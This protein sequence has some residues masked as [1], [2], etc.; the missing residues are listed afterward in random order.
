MSKQES[1]YNN[2]QQNNTQKDQVDL[3]KRRFMIGTVGTSMLMAFGGLGGIVADASAANLLANKSFNPNIWIELNAEGEVLINIAKAEMGQHIGTALARIVSDELGADWSFV[4]IHHVDSD[5]KWGF[6][7]TGGSWSVFQSFKPMSQAGAAGRISL[8]HAGAK[9]LGVSSSSCHTE[10]SFVMSGNKK[11]SFA[12]IIKKGSFDKI[13][14]PEEM[15]K[16]PLK[17]REKLKLVGKKSQAL[18]IPAK[19]N[20]SAKYGLDVELPGM[21][22][23]RPIVPPTRYG[24]KVKSVND[25]AAKGITGYLGYEMITDPS[26]TL[27]GWVVALA[28][29]YPAAMKAVQAISVS[30]Q[31]GPTANVSESDIQKEGQRLVDDKN[32]GFLFVDDGNVKAANAKAKSTLSS[33]YRTASAIHFPLEPLNATAEFVDGVCH[34]HTGNQWQSLT[35]PVVA[36]AL[37]LPA[38]NVVMHQYFL[39]GGFGRRLF[40]DYA[41]P[42]ALVAKKIGKP[43]KLIFTREDDSLFSQPRSPSV[44]RFDAAFDGDKLLSVEHAL[45]AGWPTLAMAPG[46]MPESVDKKG[47]VDPFSSSGADHWYSIENQ[48]V[49]LINN[50]L[51]Q[52]TFLPGWLRSVGPGWIGWGVESFIDELAI[53][54]K[55]DPLEFRLNLLDGKGKNASGAKRLANTLAL[56]KKSANWNEKLGKDEGIGVAVCGGQ[57]RTMP[58]WV[59][60]V[61]KVH[62]NRSSGQV[63]LKKLTLVVDC[64]LVVHPDGALAQLEGSALWGA[65]LA[66]HEGNRFKDG[67]ISSVNLNTYTPLRMADLPE[68]DIHFVESEE[69]PV[70]LG[71]PGVIAVAPA[72]GNAIYNAVGVRVKDLPIRADDVK[73]LLNS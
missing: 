15:E 18:D 64:G 29:S 9:L 73:Q 65:S 69:H 21:V 72:I 51:A 46:F 62:V 33:T 8:I 53:E 23:A 25:D 36:K 32:Q 1:Y 70:G 47:R 17:P 68:L 3:T 7:V 39:G 50:D 13:L 67:K 42:A 28:K 58:T 35:L 19:T 57:E 34:V 49:R 20:G 2:T 45:T 66:L 55:Q 59:A 48:Q 12:D 26:D 14:T 37:G 4:R 61:A 10:N 40:G 44:Q 31:K 41:I 52:R 6:M 30:Y 11:I 71:E 38:E 24:S 5:P 22:Y 16:L 54:S 63:S 56:A 43:V 27:Q 60:C